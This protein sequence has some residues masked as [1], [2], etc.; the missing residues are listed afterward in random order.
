VIRVHEALAELAGEHAA[1]GGL[2]GPHQADQE[3]IIVLCVRHLPL[4]VQKMKKR[5]VQQLAALVL[6]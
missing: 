4:F 3:N 5:P 6:R 1:D 2:A